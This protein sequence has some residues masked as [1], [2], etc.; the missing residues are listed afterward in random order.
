[1]RSIT[2]IIISALGRV[3]SPSTTMHSDAF[4]VIPF[5]VQHKC[6]INSLV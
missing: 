5:E 3:F 4:D 1:M 2:M 6:P